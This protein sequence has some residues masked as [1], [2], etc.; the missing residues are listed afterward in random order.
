[1]SSTGFV[2]EH[3]PECRSQKEDCMAVRKICG[4]KGCRASPRCEH[5]WWF[6]VMH[7]GKR[8]R[9]RVDDFALARGATEPIVSKQTVEH[10]WKPKFLGEIIAGRHPRVGLKKSAPENV[11][12]VA[13]FLDRYYTNYV[14]AEGLKSA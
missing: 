9:M 8:W 13:E 12:M 5:P 6:D 2:E 11:V 3:R 1:M 10:V 7:D 4:Q 14:E